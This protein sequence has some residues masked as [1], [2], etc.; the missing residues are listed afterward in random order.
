MRLDAHRLLDRN[1]RIEALR[2]VDVDVVR[3]QPHEALREKVLRVGGT[4]IRTAPAT[5][6][7]AQCAVLE[8]DLDILALAAADGLGDQQLIVS[9]AVKIAVSINETPPS[10]AA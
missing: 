2:P 9:P 10:K 8:A 6:R 1:V 5:G 3:V 4:V 7:I